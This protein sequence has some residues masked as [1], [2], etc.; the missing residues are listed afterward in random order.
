[1]RNEAEFVYT[2]Y[3]SQGSFF[4]DYLFYIYTPY[5]VRGL[6]RVDI[7]SWTVFCRQNQY[8][9]VCI[10]LSLKDRVR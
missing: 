4:L 2:S 1:M 9:I 5:S 7:S 10:F 6:A 8:M 3:L